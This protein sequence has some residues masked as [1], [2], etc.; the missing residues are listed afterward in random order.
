MIQRRDIND[1]L[2]WIDEDRD[3]QAQRARP[4]LYG[5]FCYYWLGRRSV[6]VRARRRRCCSWFCSKRQQAD[7]LL[8]YRYT[9]YGLLVIFE[10]NLIFH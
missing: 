5:W 2:F 1:I 7:R 6:W 9:I 4:F 3:I 10:A 8:L